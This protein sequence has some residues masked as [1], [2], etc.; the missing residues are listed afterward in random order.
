VLGCGI[1]LTGG[2]GN[3]IRAVSFFI[4]P[5][6]CPCE[7]GV[8]TTDAFGIPAAGD[9]TATG[10]GGFGPGAGGTTGF[11]GEGTTGAAPG[12]GGRTAVG[13]PGAAGLTEDGTTGTLGAGG[14]TAVGAAGLATGVGTA[15]GLGTGV[16][17]TAAGGTNEPPPAEGGVAIFSLVDSFF[18]VEAESLG[19]LVGSDMRTVSRERG[20]VPDPVG[21]GGNVIRTVS[22][23]GS[24]I[25]YRKI[26]LY[27][28]LW[29]VRSVLYTLY[30]IL[31]DGVNW[32]S[33]N[34]QKRKLYLPTTR[35][36]I[37][38]NPLSQ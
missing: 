11:A 19:A 1:P 38:T 2:P 31:P 22:F 6:F 29:R 30:R 25:F 26:N 4:A 18:G 13:A 34:A 35:F 36:Q 20:P 12:V 14:L 8:I 33:M 5:G 28:G 32:I 15:T 10:P 24:F 27:W 23:F 21:R 7:D 37:D 9:C 17:E 16:G 3:W